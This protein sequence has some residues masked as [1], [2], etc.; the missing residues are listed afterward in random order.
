MYIFK[1]AFE[2]KQL[3]NDS[4]YK[5]YIEPFI[6]FDELLSLYYANIY[7]S[8]AVRIKSNLLSQIELDQSDLSRYISP[9]FSPKEFLKIFAFNLELYGNAGLERAG[10]KSFYLY[11]IKGDELRIDKDGNIYQVTN[12]DYKRLEGHILKYYSPRSHYY[13]EPDYLSALKAIEL[14]RRADTYNEKFF[15]NGAR[16]DMAIIYENAE[17]SAEQLD[18]FRQFFGSFKGYQNSHNTLILFGSDIGDKDAKIRFE[19]LGEVEDL[20]FEKLKKV[21]RDE[22]A[23]AHGLPPRLMGIT[24]SSALGGSG[25]LI[26]QL[27]QF[28][29]IEIKPKIELI[30]QFFDSIGIKVRLKPIDVTN[31]KDD[32]DIVTNLV[33]TGIISATEAREILGWQKS[34]KGQ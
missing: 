11:N 19:K 18:A 17:P 12:D 31:F 16:P 28:N 24:E 32:G 29:E 10:A 14:N 23:A 15:D 5:E 9:N 30:E 33:S 27:H 6:G 4:S 7:H 1:S 22:I 2:S 3:K 34:L 25:E 8:R 21:S 13:G 20:S 26:G